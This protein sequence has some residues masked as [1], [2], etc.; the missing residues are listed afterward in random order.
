[1][2]NYKP[3][4]TSVRNCTRQIE[5]VAAKKEGTLRFQSRTR[6][7]WETMCAMRS[8]LI[9]KIARQT[10]WCCR[11]TGTPGS[12]TLLRSIELTL[13]RTIFT[14]TNS[15][16]VASLANVF[17]HL[18]WKNF[19]YFFFRRSRWEPFILDR[20]VICHLYISSHKI[21]LHVRNYLDTKQ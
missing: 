4:Q 2:K 12:S 3:T 17:A 13:L 20:H 9:V 11:R 7:V 5:P 8:V 16:K 14:T 21:Q 6:R 1:M 19:T 10:L 18:L 15:S